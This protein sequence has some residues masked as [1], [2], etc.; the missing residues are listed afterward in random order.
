[1]KASLKENVIDVGKLTEGYLFLCFHNIE[2]T[3]TGTSFVHIVPTL[4]EYPLTM[5]AVFDSTIPVRVE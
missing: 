1:M 5:F 3:S 2:I 4:L